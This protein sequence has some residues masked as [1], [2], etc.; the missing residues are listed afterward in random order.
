[1]ATIK[2][3][4]DVI[5]IKSD[6]TEKD[7]LRVKSF[8]PDML[9]LTDEDGNEVFGIDI[10]N[11]SYSKY[12]ICFCSKDAEGKLFM[13]MN[14]PCLK[15]DDAERERKEVVECFAVSLNKLKAIEENVNSA[16]SLLREMEAEADNAV[17]FA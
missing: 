16:D 14:N 6:L 5:Q 2:I 4:G 12:G 1:M 8:A 3:M 7:V 17:T 9:K 15:H 13:T 10:G 11:P